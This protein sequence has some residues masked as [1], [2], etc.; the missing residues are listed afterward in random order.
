MFIAFDGIDGAGKSSQIQI[1]K[2]YF[3]AKGYNVMTLDMGGAKYFKEY[4]S[5]INSGELKVDKKIRELIYY[6]EGLYVNLNII[7]DN[8]PNDILII[9]RYYLSYLA[10]GQLNGI[11]EEQ[12]KYFIK[13]LVEPDLYFYFDLPIDESF[14]RITSYR[15]IDLPE[16]GF[17]EA[18][19][20][21]FFQFQNKVRENYLKNIKDNHVMI[22]ATNSKEEISKRIVYEIQKVFGA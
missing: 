13:N 19:S 11:P 4:I 6:F 14:R 3:S 7:R 10:Y 16:V 12:I 18:D 21:T 9:D 5:D 8:K 1:V 15:K 22:D 20:N 2:D 17:G